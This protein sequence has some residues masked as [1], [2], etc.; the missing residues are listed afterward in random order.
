MHDLIPIFERPATEVL[1]LILR[2]TPAYVL[3]TAAMSPLFSRAIKA[4][5]KCYRETLVHREEMLKI[6][7]A[8]RAVNRQI[9]H[10]RVWSN[11]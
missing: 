9:P 7:L 1:V 2:Q 4:L 5:S 6:R 10:G 11:G 3:L 8:H